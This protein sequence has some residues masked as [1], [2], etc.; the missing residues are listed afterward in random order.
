MFRLQ[1]R[2]AFK[3]YIMPVILHL[4][5]NSIVQGVWLDEDVSRFK[6]YYTCYYN[7]YFQVKSEEDNPNRKKFVASLLEDALKKKGEVAPTEACVSWMCDPSLV[8]SRTLEDNL[9]IWAYFAPQGHFIESWG[10]CYNAQEEE[11][12]R[13]NYTVDAIGVHSIVQLSD[14]KQRLFYVPST[15]CYAKG[16]DLVKEVVAVLRGNSNISL[17]RVYTIFCQDHISLGG[18]NENCTS[19]Q[20]HTKAISSSIDA[21]LEDVC[22]SIGLAKSQCTWNTIVVFL[23]MLAAVILLNICLLLG[24]FCTKISELLSRVCGPTHAV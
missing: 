4:I 6:S 21:F 7:K 8:W 3:H 10:D 11:F 18:G 12:K 24:F 19:T 2:K 16:P 22:P 17:D 20:D 13:N 9:E 1:K 23:Y 5:F 14:D 15:E